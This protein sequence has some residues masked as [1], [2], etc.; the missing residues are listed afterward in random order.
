MKRFTIATIAAVAALV[1]LPSSAFAG[2]PCGAVLCLS[3][4]E[5]APHECKD[6]VADYFKIKVRR[7]GKFRPA[8]T[9]KKRAATVL[10]KCEG[11]PDMDRERINAKYGSLE[12]SPFSFY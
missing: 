8:E 3:Q 2:D 9:A 11:V 5:S 7:H 6:H 1:A 12:R 10:D 4:N